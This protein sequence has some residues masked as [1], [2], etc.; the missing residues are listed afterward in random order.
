MCERKIEEAPNNMNNYNDCCFTD[1]CILYTQSTAKHAPG[2]INVLYI[3]VSC[4]LARS[5]LSCLVLQLALETISICSQYTQLLTL[6]EIFHFV[7]H[8]NCTER[9]CFCST[10]THKYEHSAV[11][12]AA[13][14]L[15]CIRHIWLARR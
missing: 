15:N 10:Q 1:N 4:R 5:P 7:I 6:K 12:T 2:T 9:R 3:F 11:A 13:D 8:N 14:A